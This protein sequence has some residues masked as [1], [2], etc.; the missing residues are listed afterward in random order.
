MPQLLKVNTNRF[1]SR[2][3]IQVHVAIASI[4]NGKE[5]NAIFNTPELFMSGLK[6]GKLSLFPKINTLLDSLNYSFHCETPMK[7]AVWTF[8]SPTNVPSDFCRNRIT[9]RSY[10]SLFPLY[11][12]SPS[13]GDTG[14][15]I[16]LGYREN[17]RPT[18]SWTRNRTVS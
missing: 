12:Y 2:S 17:W 14:R 11:H 15:W 16:L 4:L 1:S 3:I 8:L 9:W 10:I 18:P 6:T 13:L 7:R 5:R